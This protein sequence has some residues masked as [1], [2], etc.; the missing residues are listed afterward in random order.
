M[1]NSKISWTHATFNGW[2]GCTKVAESPACENCYAEGWAK[3]TGKDIWGAR[4]PREIGTESYWRQPYKWN[5][6]AL[7]AGERRR[8]FCASLGDVFEGRKDLDP[9]RERLWKL[10]GDTPQL[11]WLLLTKRPQNIRRMVPAEWL[12]QP[13]HN[14]WYGTTAETQKWLDI[15]AEFF[16]DLPAAVTFVSAE[17]LMEPLWIRRWTKHYSQ[18]VTHD[19]LDAP[20]GAMVGGMER[21]GDSWRRRSNVFDWLIVGGESGPGARRTDLSVFR[22]LRDQCR[23]PGIAFFMKQKGTVLAREMH[24]KDRAGADIDEFPE[25]LRIQEFPTPKITAA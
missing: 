13:R 9:Q 23:A 18:D 3:R 24:C 15:R 14:V 22:D 19:R 12:S 1:E 4:K 11:D 16:V 10:I 6:E 20:D 17:P 8:V 5:Q 2:R 7:A 25:D 21:V